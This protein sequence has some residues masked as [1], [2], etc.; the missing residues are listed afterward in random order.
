MQKLAKKFIDVMK[1]CSYVEKNGTNTYHNY[2]YATSADV[3]AK[4][5]ASLVKHGIASV[6][7]PELL[8]MADVT[9]AKGNAEKLAT[10]QMQITLIDTESGETFTIVG[11]GSGQDSGDK[12]VMK[13][14]TAAIKYAYM[15]SL[16]ISTGDDPEADLQTDLATAQ[17]KRQTNT[18]PAAPVK[19]V[20]KAQPLVC[21]DCGAT[22]SDKVSRYS[23]KQFGRPLCIRCQHQV[24]NIA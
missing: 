23:Q 13:A 2:Q 5:N 12:A 15:L 1:E 6:A 18:N 14:E 4:V 16:A 21:A 9:T 10:I 3:L 8:D 20:S 24:S 17:Q 11:I 19:P 7:V 22:I